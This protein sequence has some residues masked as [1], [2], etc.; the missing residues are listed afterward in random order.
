MLECVHSTGLC[1][2][3]SAVTCLLAGRQSIFK[4]LQEAGHL[5]ERET[6]QLYSEALGKFLA[7][8]FVSG[9]CPKCGFEVCLHDY[10]CDAASVCR[11]P[12]CSGRHVLPGCPR[13]SV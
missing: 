2:V 13:R 11:C 9:T 3:T 8:R 10:L 7:D 4:T 5:E 6:E 12:L 1:T